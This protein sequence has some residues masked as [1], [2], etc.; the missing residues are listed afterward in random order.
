LFF[1]LLQ[2]TGGAAANVLEIG[3]P[4]NGE[5]TK[6]TSSARSTTP[7]HNQQQY[8]DRPAC[9]CV[10]VRVCVYAIDPQGKRKTERER[11]GAGIHSARVGTGRAAHRSGRPSVVARRMLLLL[12]MMLLLLLLLL[13]ASTTVVQRANAAVGGTVY[14]FARVPLLLL[15]LPVL[16]CPSLLR[17]LYV[18]FIQF[19]LLLQTSSK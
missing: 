17:S 12:R 1:V 8:D 18:A 16:R 13:A 6:N 4:I 10:C 9:A 11:V 15:L 2:N 5:K 19:A 3:A 14:V 7:T